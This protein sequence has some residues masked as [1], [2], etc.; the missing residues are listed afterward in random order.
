MEQQP[1]L[2]EAPE[3]ERSSVTVTV[4]EFAVARVAVQI[5]AIGTIEMI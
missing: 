2:G 4:L 3:A 1:I 5:T